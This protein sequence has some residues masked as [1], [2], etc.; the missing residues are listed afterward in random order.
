ML[1]TRLS[2]LMLVATTMETRTTPAHVTTYKRDNRSLNQEQFPGLTMIT[3]KLREPDRHKIL[4][5]SASCQ[6]ERDPPFP[7]TRS[8]TP[9]RII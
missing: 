5:T 3:L 4:D 6:Q 2:G 1:P 7:C 8:L 9:A